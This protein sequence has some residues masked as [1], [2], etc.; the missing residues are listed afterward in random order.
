[1]T[2]KGGFKNVDIYWLG[3]AAFRLKGKDAT[4]IIDPFDPDFTGLK[5]PKDLTADLVLKTHDHK[6]HSNVSAVSGEKIVIS[7]PGEYEIKGVAVTGVSVYHDKKNGEERG[8]NTIYNVQ[9]DGLN[10]V[11]LG[12]LGHTLSEEHVAQVGST[13]ILLIPVGSVYTIDAKDASE[14]VV[15]LEP[16]I[17][18]PMHYKLPGLKFELNDVSLFLKEMGAEEI[19]T[20]AKLTI[21]KEKLP[22]E[23]VVV[24]LNP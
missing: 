14:V 20:Q 7:G 4:V 21:T 6:D 15:Q 23:P 12:D 2:G 19:V 10:V 1:M 24:V 9:I 8:R 3:Q 11:H 13:D 17:I 18:I 22:D 16:K 5:L